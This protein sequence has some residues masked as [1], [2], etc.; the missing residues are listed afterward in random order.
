[1]KSTIAVILFL[2]SIAT[3]S[4]QDV[5]FSQFYST[6]H[7]TNSAFTGL[8]ENKY[9][10]GTNVKS[11]WYNIQKPGFNTVSVFGDMRFSAFKNDYFS[12]GFTL[13]N[14]NTGAGNLSYSYG[15]LSF[16]YFK[17]LHS[18]RYSRK[19]HYLLIGTQLGYG[20]RYFGKNIFSF[21]IQF[22]KNKQIYDP[23]I[24]DGEKLINGKSYL[25]INLGLAY[26]FTHKE[27]SFYAG[28][29]I[30]HINRPNISLL[31]NGNYKLTPRFSGILGGDF[32]L[33][34]GFALLPALF[35][36]LQ[37]SHNHFLLGS[38]LRY[39]YYERD[40]NAFRIGGWVRLT[41]SIDGFEVSGIVIS[42]VIELN[43]LNIGLSYDFSTSSISKIEYY[44][45]SFELS[46]IYKWGKI[47]ISQVISCPRF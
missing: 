19:T 42:S 6:P 10:V 20:N 16:S 9:R 38:H 14:D 33:D 40:N 21:G 31:E 15:Q 1:M 3:I 28:I 18:S 25:D 45:N 7:F 22:D 11:Q 13:L 43:S 12:A 26:Y 34:K 37:G 30:S 4:A 2:F 46:V 35:F 27:G 41:D 44:N 24:P 17:N 23:N 47:P 36:N 29:N 32:N 39:E 8:F 5:I